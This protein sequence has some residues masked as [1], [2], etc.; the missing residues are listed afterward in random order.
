LGDHEVAGLTFALEKY[1]SIDI[2]ISIKIEYK[3]TP[4]S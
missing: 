1:G 3:K 2:V 4:D